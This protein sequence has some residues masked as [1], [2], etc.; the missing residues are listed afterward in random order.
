MANTID[1]VLVTGIG[2]SGIAKFVSSC[3]LELLPLEVPVKFLASVR[4]KGTLD[5]ENYRE[6]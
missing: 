3:G 4:I 6:A 1:V 2:D 5:V